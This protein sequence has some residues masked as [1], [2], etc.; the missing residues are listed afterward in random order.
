[1]GEEVHVV[2]KR[3][4]DNQNNDSLPYQMEERE[5]IVNQFIA[6][7]TQNSFVYSVGTT[8]FEPKA[9]TTSWIGHCNPDG[10]HGLEQFPVLH[11]GNWMHMNTTNSIAVLSMLGTK[12]SV[13][14]RG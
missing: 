1:M 14:A 13:S 12:G 10:R 8:R 7:L 11:T 6:L 5:S 4:N 9:R 2:T 3:L